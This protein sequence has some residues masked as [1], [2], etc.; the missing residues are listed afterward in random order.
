MSPTE[1]KLHEIQQGVERLSNVMA[2]LA[3][4]QKQLA[5]A[6]LAAAVLSNMSRPVSVQDVLNVVVGVNHGVY[7]DPSSSGYQAWAA[8]QKGNL[9]KPFT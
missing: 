3:A 5:V 8:T 2:L 9:Q 4:N 7:P 1:T 6:T